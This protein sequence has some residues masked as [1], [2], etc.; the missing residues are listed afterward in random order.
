MNG[1]GFLGGKG[2]IF[3]NPQSTA[4]PSHDFEPKT[5][6]KKLKNAWPETEIRITGNTI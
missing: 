6:Q 4:I 2:G 5:G 3:K 1:K